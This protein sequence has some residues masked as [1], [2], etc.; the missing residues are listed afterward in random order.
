MGIPTATNFFLL[1][2]P[3]FS[4]ILIHSIVLF[5]LNFIK[6]KCLVQIS[7]AWS[8]VIFLP[9]LIITSPVSGS[10]ISIAATLPTAL[11]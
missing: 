8:L 1:I 5:A 10:K 7:A 9:P 4:M 3:K 6:S 11:S 2:N